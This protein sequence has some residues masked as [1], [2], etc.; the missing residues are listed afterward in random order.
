MCVFLL[1]SVCV[2]FLGKFYESLTEN[3]IKF[4]SADIEKALIKTCKDAKG[5]ENRFVSLHS[6]DETSTK[7]LLDLTR[8][9]SEE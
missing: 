7:P 9:G 5:K 6:T 3:N 4:N 1:N 2:T 8:S